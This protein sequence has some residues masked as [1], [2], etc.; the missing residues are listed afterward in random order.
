MLVT[1][2]LIVTHRC[3]W[4]DKNSEVIFPKTDGELDNRPLAG[5]GRFERLTNNNYSYRNGS[6]PYRTGCIPSPC[7]LHPDL[8]TSAH[9][10]LIFSPAKENGKD[11]LILPPDCI[12]NGER[13]P[14]V[15]LDAGEYFGRRQACGPY[16]VLRLFVS[17]ALHR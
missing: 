5:K 14:D 17:S 9:R 10:L 4:E 13:Q 2:V 8:H 7:V 11:T 3:Y 16:H 15:L 12:E 6:C 1:I